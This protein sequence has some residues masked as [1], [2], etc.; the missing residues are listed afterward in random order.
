MSSKDEIRGTGVPLATPFK[1]NGKIDE[2]KLRNLIQWIEQR[3]IDFFVPCGSTSE[4]ELMSHDERHRVIEIV[5]DTTNRPIL[6]GTGHPGL[7]E[8][9]RQT[10]RAADLGIQAALIV[11]PFYFQHDQSTLIHYYETVAHQSP[12]PIYLYQV[13]IFTNVT[14]S[15]DTVEHLAQHD[16]ITGMKDSAGNMVEF[17]RF[18]QRTE[19]MN[20]KLFT[21]SGSLYASS[22]EA[23]A[24]GGI[25]A[26]ANLEPVHSC[27]IFELIQSEQHDKAHELNRAL[28]ELDQAVTVEHGIPALKQAMKIRGA[29]AGYPRKPF[30]ESS[31]SVT[32]YL[33]SMLKTL[34]EEENDC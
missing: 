14:L 16:N 8:T 26:L 27:R 17:Q 4:T 24:E 32:Q 3:E 18:Q 21:G 13:P 25:I 1:A 34:H 29:P 28:L 7:K 30:R 9:L 31:E 12:I 15:A 19:S 33:S 22:L 23:G 6:A 5:R 10:T 11:T 20:F 2:P